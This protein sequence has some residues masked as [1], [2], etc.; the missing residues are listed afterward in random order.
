MIKNNPFSL[1]KHK[2]TKLYTYWILLLIIMLTAHTSLKAVFKQA[3][4]RITQ[5]W[6]NRTLQLWVRRVFQCLRLNCRVINPHQIKPKP[7]QA[8]IIMCNHS[9]L[10]DIPLSLYA[11]PDVS[12]RMLAKAELA[13]IPLFGSAMKAA[14]FP[15]IHRSNRHQ[16]MKDLQV[17]QNLLASGVVMWIAPEGTRSRYGQLGPFKKGGFTTAIH[18]KATIIPIGIVGANR[19]LPARTN[20]LALNQ[21]AEVRIGQPIDAATYALENKE[22]LIKRVH[23]AIG[24]L[25]QSTH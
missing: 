11:F 5:P 9:S 22:E 25:L 2:T 4:G 17:V 20:K 14:D 6:V 8:T 23:Q 1:V 18:A 15:L 7:G 16:A 19:I 10:F 21:T 24:E 13:K 3:Q 12:L